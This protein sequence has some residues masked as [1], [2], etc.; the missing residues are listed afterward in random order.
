MLAAVGRDTAVSLK[1]TCAFD[2]M[3]LTQQHISRA[4][5]LSPISTPFYI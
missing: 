5:L 1:I 2:A 3:V 4:E